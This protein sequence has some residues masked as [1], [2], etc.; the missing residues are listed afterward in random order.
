LLGSMG[1]LSGTRYPP[2]SMWTLAMP[3]RVTS[4]KSSVV[5]PVGPV[6]V[7]WQ[8]VSPQRGS[9]R[10]ISKQTTRT[11]G[12]MVTWLHTTD[13]SHRGPSHPTPFPLWPCAHLRTDP[14]VS[15]LSMTWGHVYGGS[16]LHADS[17]VCD[18]LDHV[19]LMAPTS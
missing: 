18:L 5:K 17:G 6:A 14:R 15:F 1:N 16:L 4:H 9:T 10:A 3:H 13:K 19:A 7:R 8:D 2:K 12:E 11:Q